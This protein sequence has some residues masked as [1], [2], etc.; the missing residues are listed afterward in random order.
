MPSQ[1][2]APACPRPVGNPALPSIALV[3][4]SGN[5]SAGGRTTAP[6]AEAAPPFPLGPLP[7][8]SSALPRPQRARPRSRLGPLGRPGWLHV[9]ASASEN[10]VGRRVKRAER[11]P[12]LAD[13]AAFPPR[14]LMEILAEGKQPQH[15]ARLQEENG[16]SVF[17]SLFTRENY[18][19]E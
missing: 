2:W 18:S 16:Q 5:D 11:S 9:P 3:F 13:E 4:S 7:A 12:A 6:V 8:V 1:P 19:Q 17:N 14:S 15:C 10:A